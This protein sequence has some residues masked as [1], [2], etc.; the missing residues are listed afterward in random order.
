MLCKVER[1]SPELAFVYLSLFESTAQEEAVIRTPLCTLHD[2]CLL[3]S[4]A[5]LDRGMDRNSVDVML[6]T[7]FIFSRPV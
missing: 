5:G 3:A 7:G 6:L 1:I 2:D 4:M